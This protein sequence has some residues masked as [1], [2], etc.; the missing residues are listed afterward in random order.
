MR[1]DQVVFLVGGLAFGILFGFGAFH[2]WYGAPNL[3][4][5]GAGA[6]SARAT[7]PMGPPAPTQVAPQGNA[8][9]APMVAEINELKR[10]VQEDPTNLAAWVRLGNLH[11]DVQMWDQGAMYYEKAVELE[12]HNPDVMTDLGTCYRGMKQFDKALETFERAHRLDPNHHQSLF[13]TAV[14]AGFDLKQFDRAEEALNAMEAMNPPPP[15]L[16]ELRQAI[17]RERAAAGGGGAS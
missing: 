12:P 4:G 6:G 1:K 16:D 3:E 15:R 13:N 2:A 9:G 17:A 7:G 11:F 8:G 14:V 10:L 5:P